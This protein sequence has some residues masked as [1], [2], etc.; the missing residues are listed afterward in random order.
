MLT[1]DIKADTT[2]KFKLLLKRGQSPELIFEEFFEF[3]INQL[4]NGIVNQKADLSEFEKKYNLSSDEFYNQFN[5]GLLDD[6]LDFMLWSGIY[7]MYLENVRQ[8]Q[9]LK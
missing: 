7:E 6:N 1:L 9:E 2:A 4:K 8:V 5:K 3:K